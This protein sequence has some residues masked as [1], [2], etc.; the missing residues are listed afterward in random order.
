MTVRMNDGV[1]RHR[2]LHVFSHQ[3]GWIGRVDSLGWN[4]RSEIPRRAWLFKLGKVHDPTAA[5]GVQVRE[6][7]HHGIKFAVAEDLA[8]DIRNLLLGD[9]GGRFSRNAANARAGGVRD[10]PLYVRR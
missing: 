2:A 7:E 6:V 4:R 8:F 10:E 9:L 3:L 5:G 1:E